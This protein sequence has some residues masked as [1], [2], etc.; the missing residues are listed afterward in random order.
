MN[1]IKI[2]LFIKNIKYYL[3]LKNIDDLNIIFNKFL[4]D[5]TSKIG[6]KFNILEWL[7]YIENV[8]FHYFVELIVEIKIKPKKKRLKNFYLREK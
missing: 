3:G 4:N 7:F 2:F 5:I 1:I 8:F 6:D